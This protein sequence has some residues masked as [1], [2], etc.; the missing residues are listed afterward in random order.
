MPCV[1]GVNAYPAYDQLTA[2]RIPPECRA[3]QARCVADGLW[4]EQVAAMGAVGVSHGDVVCWPAG[5]GAWLHPASTRRRTLR[6]GGRSPSDPLVGG[7]GG[8]PVL[9]AFHLLKQVTT[10]MRELS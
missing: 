2:A 5:P 10:T 8:A 4:R 6:T 1:L 9:S 3:G 7:F